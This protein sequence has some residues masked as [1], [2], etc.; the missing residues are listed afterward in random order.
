MPSF[1]DVYGPPS[2]IDDETREFYAQMSTEMLIELRNAFALDERNARQGD[3]TRAF[4]R[5]R[6]E[7]IDGVLAKRPGR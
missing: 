5:A 6:I 2:D 7:L 1:E 3:V 4:C